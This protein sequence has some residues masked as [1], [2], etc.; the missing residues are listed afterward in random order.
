MPP[1]TIAPIGL[2]CKN[3][4]FWL[5][6]SIKERV[7][8]CLDNNT[9]FFHNNNGFNAVAKKLNIKLQTWDCIRW[10]IF[11]TDVLIQRICLRHPLS[12]SHQ[13]ILKFY[14][15]LFEHFRKKKYVH[16]NG[17]VHHIVL[18]KM[19]GY[20]NLFEGSI[21]FGSWVSL[22]CGDNFLQSSSTDCP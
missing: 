17:I 1:C 12:M 11:Q 2:N 22:W 20:N 3:S 15:I 16:F 13:S 6:V 7:G 19:W 8:K 5:T 10:K 9:N 21:C 18:K 4:Y 14:R